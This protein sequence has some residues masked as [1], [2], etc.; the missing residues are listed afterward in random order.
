[1]LNLVHIANL[2]FLAIFH[3]LTVNEHGFLSKTSK[4]SI[5]TPKLATFDFGELWF[6]H[7]TLQSKV[8]E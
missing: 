7:N 3:N 8:A 1:L 6:F 4:I 2:Q 5:N